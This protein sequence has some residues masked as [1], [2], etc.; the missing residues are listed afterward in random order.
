PALLLAVLLANAGLNCDFSQIGRLPRAPRVLLALA[1]GWL[2]SL[3][4]VMAVVWLIP[5]GPDRG[6]YI[7]GLALVAAVPAANSSCAWT[8]QSGGHVVASVLVVLVSTLASPLFTPWALSLLSHWTSSAQ[9]FAVAAP[10]E[11]KA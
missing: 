6:W 11:I 8:Q 4:L 3:L 1:I 9:P 7:V 10:L 2:T 5:A